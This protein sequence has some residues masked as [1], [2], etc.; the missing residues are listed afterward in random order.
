MFEVDGDSVGERFSCQMVL[1]GTNT[2]F[3][4]DFFNSTLGLT[5]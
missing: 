4:P 3:S 1:I 2:E 5:R